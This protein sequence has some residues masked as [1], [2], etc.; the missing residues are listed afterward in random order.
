MGER[1]GCSGGNKRVVRRNE[2]VARGN[3]RVQARNG[4]FSEAAHTPPLSITKCIA[5]RSTPIN[6]GFKLEGIDWSRAWIRIEEV[7]YRG[8]GT[9]NMRDV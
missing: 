8:H 2:R 9:G 3:D 1:A 6:L 5:E 4:W 7:A